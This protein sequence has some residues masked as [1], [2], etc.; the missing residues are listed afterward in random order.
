MNMRPQLRVVANRD[1]VSHTERSKA[2]TSTL[3]LAGDELVVI[4]NHGLIMR[5]AHPHDMKSSFHV[6][7][8]HVDFKEVI[9]DPDNTPA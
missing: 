6:V 5:V 4:A 2:L 7:K 9:N 3:A 8:A 1:I